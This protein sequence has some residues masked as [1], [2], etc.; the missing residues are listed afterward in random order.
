VKG[1][2]SIAPP[3]YIDGRL[4]DGEADRFAAV[5]TG[6]EDFL[7][8][9]H[10]IAAPDN[11]RNRKSVSHGGRRVDLHCTGLGKALI[12]YWQEDELERL[13]NGHSLPR[14]NDNTIATHGTLARELATVR[15]FG[16]A[17]DDEEDALGFRS[18]GAPVF[19]PQG[20][21]IAALGVTGSFGEITHDNVLSIASAVKN[22]AVECAKALT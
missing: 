5:G 20:S 8:Q 7:E 13:V 9:A 1:L 2:E 6:K 15:A 22:A 12:A 14:R 10:H 4:T 16:Y 17:T 21:V 11:G 19:D 3:Q 18:V